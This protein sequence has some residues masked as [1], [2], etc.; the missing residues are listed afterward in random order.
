MLR[1]SFTIARTDKF[2]VIDFC[3]DGFNES[4]GHR[5]RSGPEASAGEVEQRLGRVHA[6]LDL[7]I[8][9]A[10]G[11]ERS[12]AAGG[13]ADLSD[14]I[15]RV[16]DHCRR[17][18]ASTTRFKWVTDNY[19]ELGLDSRAEMLGCKPGQLCKTMVM[20][21]KRCTEVWGGV[22]YLVNSQ[23]VTAMHIG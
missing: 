5:A 15:G 2:S 23:Y 22:L 19:Y 1:V 4:N 8:A 9:R 14:P 10:E 17:G 16:K 3:K 13:A 21:N 6:R 20:E 7:L 11:I 18:R 12:F